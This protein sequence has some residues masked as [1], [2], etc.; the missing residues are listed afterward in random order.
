MIATSVPD[1]HPSDQYGVV[2]GCPSKVSR[3]ERP[4]QRKRSG[5]G[6]H[7]YQQCLDVSG[8]TGWSER[9]GE[10]EEKGSPCNRNAAYDVRAS[11]LRSGPLRSRW[12]WAQPRA[13]IVPATPITP[14]RIAVAS[15]AGVADRIDEKHP[16][17]PD[18]S[19][20]ERRTGNRGI[21]PTA[22][23]GAGAAQRR[24]REGGS[25][26]PPRPALSCQ[27]VLLLAPRDEAGPALSLTRES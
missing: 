5:N 4:R 2:T 16:H 6:Q 17:E 9:E 1:R 18:V 3:N 20:I 10:C 23:R 27:H 14:S 15:G 8:Q 13:K 19:C 12:R 26:P 11:A 25:A 24:N 7:R 22:S 21:A